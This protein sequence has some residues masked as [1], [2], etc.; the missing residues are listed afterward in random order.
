MHVIKNKSRNVIFQKQQ[1]TP[2][3]QCGTQPV[4]FKNTGVYLYRYL[5]LSLYLHLCL[6]L[7]LSIS[8]YIYIYIHTP[9]EKATLVSYEFTL[10]HRNLKNQVFPKFV[11][12]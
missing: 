5:H 3:A 9:P 8:I 11:C 2:E 7:Y 12:W 4:A 6:N 1:K 10:F